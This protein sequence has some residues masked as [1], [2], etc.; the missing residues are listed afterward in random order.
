M[1]YLYCDHHKTGEPVFSGETLASWEALWA[2]I[3]DKLGH[4]LSHNNKTLMK[5]GRRVKIDG[6]FWSVLCDSIHEEKVAA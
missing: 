3:N 2:L 6:A 4:R 5:Q 1:I